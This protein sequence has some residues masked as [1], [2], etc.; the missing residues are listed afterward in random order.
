MSDFR[1]FIDPWGHVSGIPDALLSLP[2]DRAFWALFGSLVA[3]SP[4]APGYGEVVK[5][6]KH[7]NGYNHEDG[8]PVDMPVRHSSAPGPYEGGFFQVVL[9]EADSEPFVRRAVGR[10]R[11]VQ[12][13][14]KY[15]WEVEMIVPTGSWL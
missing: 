9:Q 13:A 4:P 5:L 6:V 11:H 10:L 7:V 3:A 12:K 15:G 8:S 14:S 1:V 2:S